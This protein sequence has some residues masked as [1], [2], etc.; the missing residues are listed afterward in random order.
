MNT[1]HKNGITVPPLPTPPPP[2]PLP[3]SHPSMGSKRVATAECH[4]KPVDQPAC[5]GPAAAN[6]SNNSGC[7]S[8]RG[9]ATKSSL[10]QPGTGLNLLNFHQKDVTATWNFGLEG[11]NDSQDTQHASNSLPQIQI[12]ERILA[13]NFFFSDTC[14]FT[15]LCEEES[16]FYRGRQRKQLFGIFLFNEHFRRKL[17][18]SKLLLNLKL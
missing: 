15:L 17:L 12:K 7:T 2:P 9:R 1:C 3:P 8:F 16:A 13:R 14:K 18:K 4:L 5:L 11:R 6:I 10:H